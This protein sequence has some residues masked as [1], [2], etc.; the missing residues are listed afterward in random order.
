MKSF[1]R[2]FLKKINLHRSKFHHNIVI[3]NDL[4]ENAHNN[5]S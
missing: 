3:L 2:F 1:A 5:H 4:I